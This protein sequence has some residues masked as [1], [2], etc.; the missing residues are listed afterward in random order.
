MQERYQDIASFRLA[1]LEQA[2]VQPAASVSTVRA[3]QKTMVEPTVQLPQASPKLPAWMPEMVDVPDGPF[4]M[5]S[6]NSDKLAKSEEKPQHR[7][8]LPDFWIAKTPVTNAQFRPF[9]VGEGYT[10]RDYWTTAGWQWREGQKLIKPD[11]WDDKQRKGADYPVVGVSWFEAVAYCRWLS[12]QIGIEFRLPSEAEWEKAARGMDGRIYPWGNM[13]EE[14]RCNSAEAGL[15]RTTPVGQYPNG[16]SPYGALD[17]AGN[18]WEWVATQA[19]KSYPYQLED[20]WQAAYVENDTQYRVL[21]GG[22]WYQKNSAYVRGAYRSI[23]TNA[24]NRVGFVGLRVASHSP[25]V[26][27]P[28]VRVPQAPAVVPPAVRIPQA[29]AVVPPAVRIPQAPAVVPPAVRVPQAPVVGPT[30]RLP[31]SLP[32]LPVW[33]P[34]L[35]KVPAGPFLM[36]SSNA[37]TQAYDNEKPRHTLILPDYWIAKTP[38]TNAQFRPFVEGDGYTNRAYW[39]TAGWQWRKGEKLVKPGYWDD[40]QW[41]S[42]DY[43]VVGVSWFEAVA[44]CRWLSNQAGIEFRLPNEAEWEKAAR[45]PDGRIWP[46]GNTWEAGRC[47]SEEA[48]IER[49]TPVG[50]YP[51]GASPY[52]ALDIA[53]NAWEWMATKYGKPYPYQIED[54][55]AEVYLEGDP[56]R[57]IRG[58][59]YYNGQKNVRGAYRSNFNNARYRSLYMGLRVASCSPLPDAGS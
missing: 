19:G 17:M 7:L 27:P 54:E 35:V 13:W 21:R 56:T 9:V 3:P 44:Y 6:S 10:N 26:V 48:H 40:K 34:E 58:G 28:A 25:T 36:G 2:P 37:D 49:T 59:S 51:S 8:T 20:E 47:N 4:L 55:W 24:R 53:G 46:W 42:A 41:N 31:Q 5:G 39:T 33:V 23:S 29:P 22:S 50:Q 14:G 32:K 57:R 18:V 1:L 45:G 52:G 15:N 11:Y 43:P 38:V 30:V 12:K 16:V